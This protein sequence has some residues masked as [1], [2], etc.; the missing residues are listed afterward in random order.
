M[1]RTRHWLG[2]AS[3]RLFRSQ[4]LVQ[5]DSTPYRV[6]HDDGLVKL[7]YYPPLAA[8]ELPLES[9][10]T[11]AVRRRPHRTPLVLVPPLAVNMLIYDLFPRRS[12]VRYLRARG[13]ELYLV[14][15]GRPD[16]RHDGHT[17]ATYFAG[18]L[19]A[20]LERAVAQAEVQRTSS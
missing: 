4:R 9:G 5:A 12:L 17:L 8:S 2:N 18:K 19:P 6:L 13:F 3:D 20:L 16:R 10:E 11:V 1:T 7:R 15:W 14:D